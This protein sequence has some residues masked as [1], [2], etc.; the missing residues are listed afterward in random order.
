M[1]IS[2]RK[3][4]KYCGLSAAAIGLDAFD[5][6]LLRKA[7]ANPLA[8]PV[9]WLHGSS[10]TGCS[11]SLLNRIS[12]LPGEPATVTDVVA[13]AVNLVYHA[14]LMAPAGDSAVAEL[15]RV[16]EQGGYVLVCEGGVPTAFGGA[17]CIVYS[18]DGEEITYQQAVQE[19]SARAA[20]RVSVGTC[21]SFGGIPSAGSNPTG[22]VGV[23]QLTGRPTINISGCPANPDW[24]VWA[25]VQILLGNPVELDANSRPVALY[26]RTLAGGAAPALIHDKCPRNKFVNPGAPDEATTFSDCDGRCLIQLGCRGPHTKSRCE[27]CWNGIA[28]QGRWCIGVNAPCHGCVD[29]GFPGPNSFYEPFNPT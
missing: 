10:C 6:G 29:P 13:G 26:N 11:V 16:Y 25:I 23:Q 21:A 5:L 24:V 4:L 28:G 3:F 19:L 14:T 7:L 9:I 22:V 12:N 18:F 20:Y 2:R 1:A 27:A 17:P 8:P 15:R